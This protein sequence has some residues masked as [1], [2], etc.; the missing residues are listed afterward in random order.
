[1]QQKR[2]MTCF[3][4]KSSPIRPSEY[5][6][7]IQKYGRVSESCFL[8]AI[9]Y[10]ERLALAGHI[11]CPTSSSLQRLLGVAVMVAAKFLED[12][13]LENKRW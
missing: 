11:V 12:F 3:E 10:I 4:G 13:V 9:I 5:V 7:H 2:S 6:R 8:V 1:M